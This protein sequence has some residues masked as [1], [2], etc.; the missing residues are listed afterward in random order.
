MISPISEIYW[1]FIYRLYSAQFLKFLNQNVVVH[2]YYTSPCASF[3]VPL[4]L[5]GITYWHFDQLSRPFSQCQPSPSRRTLH[6]L[7]SALPSILPLCMQRFQE[8]KQNDCV[9]IFESDHDYHKWQS[10]AV[11]SAIFLPPQKVFST[12]YSSASKS[13][14]SPMCVVL[15]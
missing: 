8:E 2:V 5:R 11:T 4:N 15:A 14:V 10:V 13:L 7:F 12:I 6:A 9:C 3:I 1:K